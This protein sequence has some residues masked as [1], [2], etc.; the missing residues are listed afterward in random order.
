M[1]SYYK[2][3][4]ED[5]FNHHNA[6]QW[7]EYGVK[8]FRNLMYYLGYPKIYNLDAITVNDF[9]YHE[10]RKG[11]ILQKIAAP[12]ERFYF[13]LQGCVKITHKREGVDVIFAL[14]DEGNIASSYFDFFEETPSAYQIEACSNVGCLSLSKQEFVKLTQNLDQ[15]GIA[16]VLEN[17]QTNFLRFTMAHQGLHALPIE[18]RID[19]LHNM[20]PSVFEKFRDMDLAHFLGMARETFSRLKPRYLVG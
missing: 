3:F 19:A 2:V 5:N 6:Q 9:G 14:M 18:K 16:K 12:C 11:D 20:Y 1:N 15:A 17:L 8:S 4:Q 7:R 13:I 10:F